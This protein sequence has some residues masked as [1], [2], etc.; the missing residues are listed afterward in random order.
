M[1]VMAE[2][3][4]NMLDMLVTLDVLNDL[5]SSPV[6][7]VQFWNMPDIS[8]TFAVLNVLKTRPSTDLQ[9]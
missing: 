8:V 7:F 2:Q 3:P 1:T 4:L 9:P 5:R 6:S